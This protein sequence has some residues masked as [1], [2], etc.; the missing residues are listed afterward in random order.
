M[1]DL[2]NLFIENLERVRS[3][4]KIALDELEIGKT[5]TM[6][7]NK[8]LIKKL[9]EKGIYFSDAE[10]ILNK[11]N[12]I[13]V[14]NAQ[15]KP[16]PMFE[17]NSLYDSS[18]SLF[19]TFG[20]TKEDLAQ[21]LFWRGNPS[22]IRETKKEVDERIKNIKKVEEETIEL[23][24]GSMSHHHLACFTG[25]SG[26]LKIKC[27]KCSETNTFEISEGKII[28]QTHEKEQKA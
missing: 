1:L 20:I 23:K 26:K 12:G 25:I 3:V 16:N 27:V 8:I 5:D 7:G 21:Y 24:C 10:T 11:I 17:K 9:E 6:I 18:F 19:Q 13:E 15:L 22:V 14:L 4:L 2:D 28:K